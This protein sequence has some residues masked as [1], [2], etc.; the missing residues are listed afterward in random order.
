MKYFF[1]FENGK[2]ISISTGECVDENIECVEVT[3]QMYNNVQIYGTNYYIYSN[4]EVV[5]NP[6]YEAEQLQTAKENKYNEALEKAYDFEQN[7]TVEYKNCVFEMAKSNRDN[8]RDTVDALNAI[9]Q[10]ETTWN[11]KNDE[12]VILTIEDI[13]Y[14]RLNLVLG[15]I[16]KLWISDYPAYQ[17]QIKEAETVEDVNLIEIVYN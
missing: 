7:G 12:L 16:Q 8:L 14:I 4:G 2:I 13:Q 17:K 15:K 5:L 3:E 1:N 9:G 10:T 11:D 6:N